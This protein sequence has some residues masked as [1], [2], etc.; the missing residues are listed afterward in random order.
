MAVDSAGNLYVADTDNHT[1]RFG[2]V[3][4]AP[5]LLGISRSGGQSHSFLATGGE[6][7]PG[8]SHQHTLSRSVLD[9]PHQCGGDGWKQLCRYQQ[10]GNRASILQAAIALSQAGVFLKF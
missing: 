1:I 6:Q 5:P 10:P 8:G 2:R 4:P 3:A 7:L 9:A